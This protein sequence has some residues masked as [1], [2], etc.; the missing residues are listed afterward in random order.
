M[1]LRD[2]LQKSG[3][4]QKAFGQKLTP[5]ISAGK[6]NKWLQGRLRVSLREALQVH[7]VCGGAVSLQELADMYRGGDDEE[8]G[9]IPQVSGAA[10]GAVHPNEERAFV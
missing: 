9:C 4:S 3:Q 2:F 7:V 6:V 8:R 10:A 1:H 5:P